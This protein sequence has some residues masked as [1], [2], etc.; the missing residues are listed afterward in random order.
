MIAI[1]IPA[2]VEPIPQPYP[3]LRAIERDY[4]DQPLA[5]HP[6]VAALFESATEYLTPER[7]SHK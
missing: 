6:A 5:R 1:P 2:P 7:E 4:D 3:H